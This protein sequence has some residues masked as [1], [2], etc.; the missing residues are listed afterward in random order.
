M[1][2]RKR[3][4][5][6]TA[7]HAGRRTFLLTALAGLTL[8]ATAFAGIERKRRFNFRTL[9]RAE[10]TAARRSSARYTGKKIVPYSG[11][12]KPGTIVI[13]TRERALYYVLPGG[14]AERYGVG[15][16]REGFQW[17]G[18]ATIRRKAVWPEWRPPKEMIER[19]WKLYKRRLPEVMK[20][21]R[22]NPLGARALYL[23][24][25]NR[26]TL[27]RIHGTNDPTTIGR[28]VSSGCIRMLNEEII[29][30]YEKVPIGT[31][32]VVL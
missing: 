8:P 15:V 5:A 31:K 10:N 1:R 3:P 24:Q 16:G 27:Y 7:F 12:E 25:G 32:V 14:K 4:K 26:D 9:A 13:V 20:G 11:P 17:S 28:A 22:D 30:L 18:V 29:E 19:E 6:L 21:G 23:Y 2:N